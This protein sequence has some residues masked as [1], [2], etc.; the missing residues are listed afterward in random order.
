MYQN[1]FWVCSQ[2]GSEVLSDALDATCFYSRLDREK[3]TLPPWTNTFAHIWEML[4]E[5]VEAQ[6]SSESVSE[7]R[8]VMQQERNLVLLQRRRWVG[9]RLRRLQL[10][11]CPTFLFRRQLSVTVVAMWKKSKK[12]SGRNPNNFRKKSKHFEEEIQNKLVRNPKIHNCPT[13]FFHRRQLAVT[14]VAMWAVSSKTIHFI[15]LI[16]VKSVSVKH[17]CCVLENTG[18]FW[19]EDVSCLGETLGTLHM[20][21]VASVST[22]AHQQPV[23]LELL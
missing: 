21:A 17:T 20:L 2:S 1:Q 11:N 23:F 22:A 7:V 14:V 5:E 15:I 10:H 9:A 16:I 6:V 19:L 3:Y 4:H 13:F 8:P 18:V 12:N